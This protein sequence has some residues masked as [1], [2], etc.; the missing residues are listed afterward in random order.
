MKKFWKE[1]LDFFSDVEDPNE[2][3]YDPA[4]FGAMIVIVLF[5]M[6]V[7]FWLLWSLL[8]FGG[9]I[10]GKVLPFLQVV[11]TKK[12]FSDFGYVSYPYEMGV[13]EGWITNVVALVFLIGVIV[14]I[15]YVFEV[16]RREK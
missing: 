9:G 8:V 15:W 7:L 10:Q 16:K 11:F 3:G 13:F 14:A 12:T 5:V 4:H 2:P 6:T 1:F